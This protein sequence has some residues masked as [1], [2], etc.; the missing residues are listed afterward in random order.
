MSAAAARHTGLP[1]VPQPASNELLGSW[2]LRV[3]QLYALGLATLLDRLAARPGTVA[4]VPH[5][6]AISGASISLDAL[7]TA[8]RLSR[9]DLAAMAPQTCRPRWP[10]ELGACASCLQHAADAGQPITWKRNWVNPLVTVCSIHGTWLTP[11][12][13]HMLARVR[14]VGDFGG[15]VQHVAAAQG[16]LDDGLSNAGD[17]LWFQ[18]LCT[19]RTDVHF[20]WG[21]I[22]PHDLIRIVDA[23]TREVISAS[24]S[25]DSARGPS[26]DRRALSVKDFAFE[27]ASAQRVGLSLPTR[28]RQ[29]QWVLGRVAHV[30]RLAPEARKLHSSWSAASAK[31]L[32]S[33]RYWPEGALAWIC[34][35]AAELV[36]RQEELRRE[37]SFSPMY[38]KAYSALLASIH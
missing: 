37:F 23:V 15:V 9:V 21:R 8:S 32:A 1:F 17:A 2:L 35:A 38:F 26:A 19:A 13:T 33:M 3:A 25:N 29:R 20:P 18:D 5:W 4:R 36:R 6:F 34:P 11:V 31:R 10:E 24:D 28:L 12:A 30:L 27:T 16:L 22:R 14:H 7:S